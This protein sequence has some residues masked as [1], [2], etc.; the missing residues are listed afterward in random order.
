[1]A[2][3]IL[4]AKGADTEKSWRILILRGKGSDKTSFDLGAFD[5]APKATIASASAASD[6]RDDPAAFREFLRR[7]AAGVA[8]GELEALLASVPPLKDGQQLPINAAVRLAS[9]GVID[10]AK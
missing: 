10:L 9:Q 8:K 7:Y 3:R 5:L 6:V 4:P 1:V 2:L